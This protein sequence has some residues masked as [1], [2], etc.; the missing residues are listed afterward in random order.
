MSEDVSNLLSPFGKPCSICGTPYEDED[1]FWVHGYIGILPV[2]FC[3]YCY[4]GI[5]E[6]VEALRI[7]DDI[8]EVE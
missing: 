8:D 3:E 2:C 7:D 1:V 4:N 5:V 6:M